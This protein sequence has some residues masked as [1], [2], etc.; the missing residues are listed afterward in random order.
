MQRY[1]L[2]LNR[3]TFSEVEENED[4]EYVL[5]VDVEKYTKKIEKLK[6]EIAALKADMKRGI[7]RV[8]KHES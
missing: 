3:E 2:A 4:G 6:K 8:K 5:Y 7:N 1:D